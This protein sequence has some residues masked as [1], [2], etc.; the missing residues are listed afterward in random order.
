MDSLS[1]KDVATMGEKSKLALVRDLPTSTYHSGRVCPLCWSRSDY[2]ESRIV[3]R[4]KLL[5]TLNRERELS[6]SLVVYAS[7]VTIDVRSVAS[8]CYYHLLVPGRKCGASSTP[9]PRAP[10]PCVCCHKYYPTT[11]VIESS[12]TFPQSLPSLS[13]LLCYQ[14]L[15]YKRPSA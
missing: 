5:R 4:V 10:R 12:Q 8:G 1:L 7:L 13:V 11:T 6:A 3:S 14:I 15:L 2:V 9:S